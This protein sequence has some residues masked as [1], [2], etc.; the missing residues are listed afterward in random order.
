[1]R[2]LFS[3][4]KNSE[5]LTAGERLRLKILLVLA[6]MFIFIGLTIPVSLFEELSIE[7]AIIVPATSLTMFFISLLL[8]VF[9]KVRLAMHFSIYTF[10]AMTVYFV[11]GTTLLYGY[12]LIFIT[13]TIIIF[14]QDIY[15]YIV[16]GG[17]L[18]V[19]G[20]FYITFNGEQLMNVYESNLILSNSIYSFVL[21]SFYVVY[22]VYFILSDSMY[23][24]MQRSYL[25]Y[26]KY[27]E[28][29]RSTALKYL[30]DIFEKNNF[31]PVFNNHSFQKAVSE[32]AL[33][34]NAFMEKEPEKIVEVVEFYFF[35][36]K[37]EL[38]DILDNP[39][40][41]DITKKY[42]V[43]LTPYL[44]Q[45]NNDLSLIWFEFI[46][47]FKE[48]FHD[49]HMRFTTDLNSLFT[50]KSNKLVA[51]AMIYAYMR[52]DVTQTDKW[53]RLERSLNHEEIIE[54][55]R[56]NALRSVISYE[57]VAFLISNQELFDK[58]IR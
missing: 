46:V 14:Y 18:T 24:K 7:I 56:L 42:A 8:L 49:Q 43:E 30:A 26:S 48:G 21:A 50:N 32:T 55:F 41:N 44:L 29:H 34:I 45:K 54:K 1:M 53:G 12:F 40:L 25:H 36:H 38:N 47:Q 37:Y 39:K 35:L 57:D 5:F 4:L 2:T 13:L 27:N 52:H 51:L 15:T 28:H 31:K 19:Y 58:N 10:I 33:F 9:N 11:T 17:A 3:K 22:L 6:F 23:E 20:I 16:Y